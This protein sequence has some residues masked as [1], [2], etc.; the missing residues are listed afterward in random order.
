MEVGSLAERM[1]RQVLLQW[2]RL[3]GEK[4]SAFVTQKKLGVTFPMEPRGSGGI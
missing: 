2:Q 4:H 3:G 1:S